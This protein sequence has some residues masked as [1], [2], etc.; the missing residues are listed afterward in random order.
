MK[1][2]LNK[3]INIHH[4][5]KKVAIIRVQYGRLGQALVVKVKVSSGDQQFDFRGVEYVR[6]LP[7]PPLHHPGGRKGVRPSQWYDIRYSE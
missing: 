4:E 7:H 6:N 5:K 1:L 2:I 3:I